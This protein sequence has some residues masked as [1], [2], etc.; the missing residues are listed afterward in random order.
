VASQFGDFGLPGGLGLLSGLGISG[1]LGFVFEILQ[2]S[3]CSRLTLQSVA[4]VDGFLVLSLNRIISQVRGVS[5]K[6]TGFLHMY[7][8][9][10]D[11]L[12]PPAIR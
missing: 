2:E 11:P 6:R 7:I 3:G 4:S 5:V 1:G 9:A 10:G 12:P 8:A